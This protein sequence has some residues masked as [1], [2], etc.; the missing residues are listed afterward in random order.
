MNSRQPE[1]SGKGPE[2]FEP[3][4][5]VERRS[6]PFVVSE[7]SG[8]DRRQWPVRGGIPIRCGGGGLRPAPAPGFSYARGRASSACG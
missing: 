2:F 7:P 3:A 1:L 6:L 4:D 8:V 5:P